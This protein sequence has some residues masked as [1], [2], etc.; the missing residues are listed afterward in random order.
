MAAAEIGVV[1]GSGL[2]DFPGLEGVEE[3][4]L[5]TPFGPP[6]DAYRLG[7]LDGRRV[8]FLARHGR[9][10]HLSPSAINYR[11][12]LFGFKLLGASRVLS[13]SAVGSLSEAIAPLD[14]VVP[15]QFIDR[16]RHR[17]DTF[18]EDGIVAHVAFADPV[19]PELTRALAGA[20]RDLPVRLHRG[21]VYLCIEGPQFSTRAE[22]HLYRSWGASIIGMTNVQEARLAREAELCYATLALVTDYDCWREGES[23][24]VAAILATLARNAENATT[25][26]G[27]CIRSLPVRRGCACGVALRDAILTPLDRVPAATRDRLRPLLDGRL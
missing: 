23:V 11:A 7:T 15:D 13:A 21:G 4:R 20:A 16:T 18:F 2:Y 19:C 24:E 3:V 22:S 10:H 26:I 5:D 25:L 14:L 8:A 1:G 6:S 17:A 27:A 9:G 12:N